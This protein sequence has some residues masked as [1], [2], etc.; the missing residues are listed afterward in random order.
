MKPEITRMGLLDMQVCVPENLSD[1]EVLVFAGIEN[2][3][4]TENGW[5]IRKQGDEALNGCDERVKCEEREGCVHIM[6]EA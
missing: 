1:T 3:C 5:F 6:L 4:G 2:P